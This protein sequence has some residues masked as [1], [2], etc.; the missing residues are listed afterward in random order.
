MTAFLFFQSWCAENSTELK[1]INSNLEFNLHRLNFIKLITQ[2]TKSQIQALKYARNFTPY[3][4]TCSKEIQ[5]LMASLLYISNG[6]KDSPY[7]SYLSDELWDEIQEEFT[8]TSCKLMGLPIECPLKI[9][10]VYA[11]KT[12]FKSKYMFFK[13]LIKKKS[14]QAGCKALPALINIFQVMQQ[15]QVGHILNK[16]ELPIEI[17]LGQTCR[18]HSVFTCP[19]LRQQST[20]L[21][22]PMRLVCGH[23]I[24]KDALFKLN[25][26]GK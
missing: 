20:D 3:A 21:N 6:L 25:N 24:S 5:R 16:D 4:N 23:V 15:T 13:Y 18:F 12:F 10:L 19:I 17:D 7:S 2:G 22:P 8:K 1:T 9:W 11:N 26:T 14:V